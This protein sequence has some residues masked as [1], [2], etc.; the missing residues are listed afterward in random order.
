M[1]QRF[2]ELQRVNHGLAVTIL[3]V[4]FVQTMAPDK[5]SCYPFAVILDTD[6]AEIPALTQEKC[7]P[8]D[9]RGL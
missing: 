2:P 1:V 9:V 8:E 3:F 6:P 5:E 7:T 4:K